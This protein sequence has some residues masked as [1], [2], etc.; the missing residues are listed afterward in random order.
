MSTL[1]FDRGR[2]TLTLRARD[3]SESGT[4][5]AFNNVDHHAR[6]PWPPGEY[7]F[8][9]WNTHAD[10]SPDSAYG[11]FGIAVFNVP[12]REGMGVHSGRAA[13]ND[14]LGRCGPEHC[15]MGCIRTSDEAM[16]AIRN[17]HAAD[18]LRRI[19]VS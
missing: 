12:D 19:S 3:G 13:M 2:S 15:T 11:S 16:R 5:T 8:E 7:G 6:G 4:W 18:P 10:D 14:G 1:E 9:V 17:V